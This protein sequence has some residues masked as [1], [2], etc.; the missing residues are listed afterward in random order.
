VG[1]DKNTRGITIWWQRYNNSLY[2]LKC[3]CFRNT[4]HTVTFRIPWY[5]SFWN[6]LYNS[7]VH[8]VTEH[9]YLTSGSTNAMHK[10]L[11]DCFLFQY[12]ATCMSTSGVNLR[13]YTHYTDLITTCVIMQ[14]ARKPDR[15]MTLCLF[16]SGLAIIA[17]NSLLRNHVNCNLTSVS[18]SI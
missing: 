18:L 13:N 8:P 9:D 10:I 5:S 15:L 12:K 4:R 16:L 17:G 7:A 11:P 14:S 1:C 6:T 3:K 2:A